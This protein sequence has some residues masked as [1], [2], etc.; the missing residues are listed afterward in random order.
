MNPPFNS[1]DDRTTPDSLKAEAHAMHEAMFEQWIRSACAVCKPSGQLSLIARPQSLREILEACEG[2]FGGLQV[3]P[4]H[5]RPGEDAIRILLSGIKG[6][7]ARLAFR[8]P[9]YVHEGEDRAFS[10]RVDEL[11]NGRSFLRR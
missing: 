2:R 9:L 10:A 5:P 8:A 1:A 3:T 11:S 4:V 7:R 6:N